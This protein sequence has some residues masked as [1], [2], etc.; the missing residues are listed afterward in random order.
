MLKL[1]SIIIVISLPKTTVGAIIDKL[2]SIYEKYTEDNMEMMGSET[3]DEY[4][5]KSTDSNSLEKK[6]TFAN[7]KILNIKEFESFEIDFRTGDPDYDEIYNM[8]FISNSNMNNFFSKFYGCTYKSFIDKEE[9]IFHR[10]YT[11][12]DS[13]ET[14]LKSNADDFRNNLKKSDRLLHYKTL[15]S[16]IKILHSQDFALCNLSPSK[17]L[18]SSPITIKN[19]F[20]LLQQPIKNEKIQKTL[21]SQSINLQPFQ[22]F[23]LL[24]FREQFSKR[25]FRSFTYHYRT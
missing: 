19:D 21:K 7:G 15:F 16:N 14:N 2:C 3:M 25:Y 11:I 12:Q 18:S 1:L 4:F 17:I 6:V 5:K 24:D 20:T 8:I 10:I 13:I 9:D 22:F 23:L